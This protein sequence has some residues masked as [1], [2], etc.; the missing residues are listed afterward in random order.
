MGKRQTVIPVAIVVLAAALRLAFLDLKP[1]H[2]DE[3]INGW[4]CD[5]MSKNGFYAYDPSNYHGP[6]HFYVLFVSLHLLGRNLWA[7]RLP[8]VLVGIATVWLLT[9]FR[10]F[11]GA[12]I[13]YLAALA[14]AVSPGF[15]FYNRYSI[16][17]SW[18]VFFL[19]T[20]LWAALDLYSAPRK[21]SA[22]ALV[23]GIT[24]AILTKE[25]YLLHFL[26]FAA[27]VPTFW[28]LNKIRPST[29]WLPRTPQPLLTAHLWIASGIGILLLVFFYSGNFLHWSGLKGLFQTF[30]PW[31][32]TGLESAGHGKP[33]Y[34]LVPLLPHFLTSHG[35][36]SHLAALRLNWYWVKLLTV[37]EWFCLGGLVLQCAVRF[38][39]ACCAPLP[40][41][42]RSRRAAGLQYHSV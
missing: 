13:A 18:L 36:L 5:Q 28:Y 8:V 1:P 27:A 6:L 11:V 3:G 7:L 16:H 12:H 34:D 22:W 33:D 39:R 25:T 32:K 15:L 9:G 21:R 29:G 40:C 10:R 31:A 2:F 30:T 42:L 14:M 26:A 37:Y 41:D 38:R 24:G 20:I 35:P 17:E 4:F 23:L 19:L